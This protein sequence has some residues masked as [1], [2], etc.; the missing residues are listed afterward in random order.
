[1]KIVL[2]IQGAQTTESRFRGIGRYSLA[3]AEA[4]V[5]NGG[6]HEWWIAFNG[7]FNDHFEPVARVFEGL[8]PAER[9]VTWH[10]SG[11]VYGL[12][13][14]SRERRVVAEV[15]REA[16]L[17]T[18][19]PDLVHISSLFEGAGDNAVTSI[20]RLGPLYPTAVTLY[21]LIPLIMAGTYLEN[22]QVREWYSE[23]LE[24]LTRADL[25]LAIS[26]S[27]RQE[28]IQHLGIQADRIVNVSSAADARFCVQRPSPRE[29][30]AIRD[31]YKLDQPFI[32][33][34]GSDD[35]RKNADGLIRAFARLPRS[36]RQGR[37]LAIVCKL[38]EAARERLHQVAAESGLGPKE[39]VLTGYTPDDDLVNLYNLCE[40][41]VF[42]PLHEGFGLP[43]LEAMK[44]GA[45]VLASNTTSLPEVIGRDEAMFDPKDIPAMAA[46]ME[47]ALCD[48]GFR[49]NLRR[50]GLE[51]AEKFTWDR[52]ARLAISAFEGLA[53]RNPGTPGI[54]APGPVS[55]SSDA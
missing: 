26:E 18:L 24:F 1:M 37:Q 11:P 48:P 8:V 13:P 39:M 23:K 5:R 2:D 15:Y 35:P 36:V 29:E 42:P 54:G 53:A 17:S 14:K 21:D 41:F 22:P 32:M 16:F 49:E 25:V 20:G 30:A 33:Y 47:R 43:A 10:F 9:M 45:P 52:S 51:Q 46:L 28:G 38:H 50:Q 7:M 34:T 27:S 4:M 40:L 44:C 6:R 12:S 3:L 19:K 55:A 31:H